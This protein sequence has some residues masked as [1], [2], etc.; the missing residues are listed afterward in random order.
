MPSEDRAALRSLGLPE[1]QI[2]DSLADRGSG[3]VFELMPEN[4]MA[5]GVWNSLRTQWR[6]GWSGPTGLDYAVLPA[7]FDLMGIAA[8]E[9][10]D[11]FDAV[12]ACESVALECL[13]D[14]RND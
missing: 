7:V 12:R 11:I 6:V 10:M 5:F 4:V 8:G 2:D 1:W 9:R 14:G 13:H 3:G